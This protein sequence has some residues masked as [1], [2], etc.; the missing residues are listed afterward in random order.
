LAV[1]LKVLGAHG[2]HTRLVVAVPAAITKLPAAQSAHG[3]HVATF[4]SVLNEFAPHAAHSRFVVA[5]PA[6]ITD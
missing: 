6:A 2:A 4:G 5:V 1:A 3:V